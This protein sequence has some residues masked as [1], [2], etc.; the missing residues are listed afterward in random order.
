MKDCIPRELLFMLPLS[1]FL[2]SPSLL[3]CVESPVVQLSEGSFEMLVEQLDRD[4]PGLESRTAIRHIKSFGH[5]VAHYAQVEFQPHRQ[6]SGADHYYSVGCKKS[7]NGEW[8]CGEREERREIRFV[9][10]D[11]HVRIAD[12]IDAGFANRIAKSIRMELFIDQSGLYSYSKYGKIEVSIDPLDLTYI[13][14]NHEGK[15]VAH[16]VAPG[17]CEVHRI[18][19]R[20]IACGLNECAFEVV[21]NEILHQA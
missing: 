8:S 10:P 3:A 18:V 5:T 6:E 2:I 9:D 21:E 16:A 7:E 13:Y 14:K 15:Y 4:F 20:E 17:A 1:A 11:D 12:D 19:V